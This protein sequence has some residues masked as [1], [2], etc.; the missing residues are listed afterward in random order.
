M[1]EQATIPPCKCGSRITMVNAPAHGTFRIY[2]LP[3]GEYDT[4]FNDSV[5]YNE[6]ST[7]WCADCNRIRRDLYRD[8]EDNCIKV[9]EVAHVQP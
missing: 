1:R 3:D 7:V 9:K 5:W 2:Y 4:T 6:S 8:E